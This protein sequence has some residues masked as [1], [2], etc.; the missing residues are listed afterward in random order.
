MNNDDVQREFEQRAL[1][2]VRGLVDKMD[3]IQDGERRTQKRIFGALLVAVILTIL[4][5][6]WLIDRMSH[7]QPEGRVVETARPAP[8]EQR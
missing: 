1:R 2:N 3:A 4:G 6:L 7:R 5:S 8:A